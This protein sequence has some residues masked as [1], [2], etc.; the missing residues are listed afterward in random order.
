MTIRE[1]KHQYRHK[2]VFLGIEFISVRL[3]LNLWV[4]GEAQNM[5]LY[6]IFLVFFSFSSF[7]DHLDFRNYSKLRTLNSYVIYLTYISH[8]TVYNFSSTLLLIQLPP[9]FKHIPKWFLFVSLQ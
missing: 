8:E 1:S 7:W 9:P 5:K 6:E 3:Y 4:C 2:Y